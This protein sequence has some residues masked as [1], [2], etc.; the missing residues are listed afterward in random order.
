MRKYWYV[1]IFL[2]LIAAAGILLGVSTSAKKPD[3]F[4]LAIVYSSDT[5]GAIAPCG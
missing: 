5:W 4:K 2:S 3:E 1:A